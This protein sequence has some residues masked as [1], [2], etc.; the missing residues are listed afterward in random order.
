MRHYVPDEP[1]VLPFDVDID[2]VPSFFEPPPPPLSSPIPLSDPSPTESLPR[3]SAP[4]LIGSRSASSSGSGSGLSGLFFTA[5]EE[6]E[7][8]EV[9]WGRGRGGE[10]GR[11]GSRFMDPRDHQLQVESRGHWP[12]VAAVSSPLQLQPDDGA[13]PRYPS[14]S[15]PRL[16]GLSPSTSSEEEG[17]GG[18]G[19]AGEDDGDGPPS[20]VASSDREGE[21]IGGFRYPFYGVAIPDRPQSQSPPPPQASLTSLNSV[22]TQMT[23]PVPSSVYPRPVQHTLG[24]HSHATH[25]LPFPSPS[26]SFSSPSA[27][28]PSPMFSTNPSIQEK[29]QVS[30]R[31]RKGD[32][33]Y[34]HHLQRSGEIPPVGDDERARIGNGNGR[35]E[36]NGSNERA[37]RKEN[38]GEDLCAVLGGR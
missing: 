5:G 24:P 17:R 25:S 27:P 36:G 37:K 18:H 32:I 4:G 23:I 11:G 2:T 20:L 3:S 9:S 21:G 29:D 12:T 16:V 13:A 22:P 7:R 14:I 10:V 38:E 1:G 8:T 31:L 35:S 30:R 34:W 15:P 28:S 33:L 6:G 26:S 19:Q